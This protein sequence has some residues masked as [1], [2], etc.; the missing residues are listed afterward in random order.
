MYVLLGRSSLSL[1]IPI[2]TRSTLQKGIY[3]DIY[4][5]ENPSNRHWNIDI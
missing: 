2:S 3:K 5:Y 1:Q 4:F